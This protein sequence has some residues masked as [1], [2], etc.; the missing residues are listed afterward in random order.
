MWKWK[1]M[2]F[3]YVSDTK[4]RVKR[5]RWHENESRGDVKEIR[6]IIPRTNTQFTLSCIYITSTLALLSKVLVPALGY[7]VRDARK[8]KKNDGKEEKKVYEKNEKLWMRKRDNYPRPVCTN[9][10]KLKKKT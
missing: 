9:K 8:R 6:E 4:L 10:K 7:M 1:E 5:G 3:I 2:K